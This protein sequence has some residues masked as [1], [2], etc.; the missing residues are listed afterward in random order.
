[1]EQF[2]ISFLQKAKHTITVWPGSF[3]PKYVHHGIK[4]GDSNRYLCAHVHCSVIHD[5]Q[6]VETTQMC[7]NRWI[8]KMLHI[9]AMEYYLA[10]EILT[11]AAM[12]INLEN[13][14]LSEI[15]ES[16]KEKC[17]MIPLIWGT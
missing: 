3:T 15:S 9:P 14:M 17:S 4:S 10:L 1:M 8:N 13:N 7:I 12:W 5:S 6:E 11:H 16:H 2:G